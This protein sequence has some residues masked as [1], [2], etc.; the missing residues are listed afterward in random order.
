MIRHGVERQPAA[1]AMLQGSL[2]VANGP[3]PP[4]MIR[5][6]VARRRHGGQPTVHGCSPDPCGGTMMMPWSQ[7]LD[8]I[9][10]MAKRSGAGACR[11]S[12]W[13]PRR[14]G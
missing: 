13:K 7:Y 8:V 1:N 11:Q 14:I 12:D 4:A 3:L 10:A 5:N 6:W 9:L 2:I